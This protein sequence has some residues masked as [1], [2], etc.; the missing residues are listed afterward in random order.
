[1]KGFVMG[2]DEAKQRLKARISSSFLSQIPQRLLPKK[3]SACISSWLMA[4]IS[5]IQSRGFVLCAIVSE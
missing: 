5:Q 2:T 3:K 1:M 4:K